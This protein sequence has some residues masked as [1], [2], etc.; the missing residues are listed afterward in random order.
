MR[1]TYKNV[2]NAHKK[3]TCPRNKFFK[4][5]IEANKFCYKKQHKFCVNLLKKTT[6]NYYDNLN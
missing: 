1:F 4:N 3:R 6:K 5:T 2:V